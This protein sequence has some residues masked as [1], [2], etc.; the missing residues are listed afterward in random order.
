MNNEYNK[1]NNGGQNRQFN[2][3]EKNV[4]RENTDLTCTC[5]EEPKKGFVETAKEMGQTGL[6]TI[7]NHP[8][9]TAGAGAAAIIIGKK[10][11]PSSSPWLR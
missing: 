3:T 2:N 4:T 10:A 1:Q 6:T 11:S 8:W 9:E 7:K 5:C